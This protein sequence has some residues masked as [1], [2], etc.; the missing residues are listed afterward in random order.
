MLLSD[1]SNLAA[2]DWPAAAVIIAAIVGA[3]TALLKSDWRRSQ[4][5][6]PLRRALDAEVQRNRRRWRWL[7]RRLRRPPKP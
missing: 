6:E 2:L 7:V 4:D 3:I 5:L 1:I